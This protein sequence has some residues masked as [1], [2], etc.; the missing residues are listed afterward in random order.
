MISGRRKSLVRHAACGL[1]VCVF[2]FG[3]AESKA[4][5]AS[6][7]VALDNATSKNPPTKVRK[8]LWPAPGRAAVSLCG[9]KNQGIE[10]AVPA[11]APIVAVEA[12]VVAYAGDELKSYGNLIIIRH[13]NGFVS[14]YA[15]VPNPRVSRGEQVSRG[16]I[17]GAAGVHPVDESLLHFELRKGSKMV[18]ARR[19]LEPR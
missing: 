5:N 18:D 13:H 6:K 12:G 14:A 17:I 7:L 9:L 4:C 11:G 8:F 16:Q 1:I 19:Y 3:A 15:H 2:A 10:L